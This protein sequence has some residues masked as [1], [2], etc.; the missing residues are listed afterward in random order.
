[1]PNPQLFSAADAVFDIPDSASVW[2]QFVFDSS[3]SAFGQHQSIFADSR[4]VDWCCFF[5]GQTD[6]SVPS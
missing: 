2:I 6:G 4:P 1:M 3:Q 5:A